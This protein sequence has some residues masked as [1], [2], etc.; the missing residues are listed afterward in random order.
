MSMEFHHSW[1][2][3]H[4]FFY[5]YCRKGL[6]IAGNVEILRV[7]II[8][9]SF[10]KLWYELLLEKV[11]HQVI[12]EATLPRRPQ[13][14][15]R[16]D[17]PNYYYHNDLKLLYCQHSFNILHFVVVSIQ[18]MFNQPNYQTFVELQNAIIKSCEN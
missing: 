3:F 7:K 9:G 2:N 5:C 18:K 13:M 8:N 1:K 10:D 6:E 15:V 11:Y 4:V 16:Y 12:E 17:A 14:P